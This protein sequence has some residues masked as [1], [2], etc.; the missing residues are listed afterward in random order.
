MSLKDK[1]IRVATLPAIV[2][3]C[4]VAATT[5]L[6]GT[7]FS[8]TSSLPIIGVQLPSPIVEGITAGV[9]SGTTEFVADFILP[10]IQGDEKLVRM[11]RMVLKPALTGGALAGLAYFNSNL[12][13]LDSLGKNFLIGAGSEV[14]GTYV[15]RVGKEW[16][17]Q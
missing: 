5:L 6:M 14:A 1:I 17:S 11:E 4:A 16:L 2:G 7:P 3:G 13:S 12:P 10:H 15:Y 9:A 8:D